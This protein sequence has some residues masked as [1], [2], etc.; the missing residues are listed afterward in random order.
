MTEDTRVLADR[1]A[2]KCYV[3]G[4][5][6]YVPHYIN[7]QFYVG[8]GFPRFQTKLWTVED[9]MRAGAKEKWLVLWPRPR[10]GQ[11]IKVAA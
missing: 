5:I 4:D 8:P 1:D 10:N 3:F 9:L 7:D 6:T 2:I 11:Q